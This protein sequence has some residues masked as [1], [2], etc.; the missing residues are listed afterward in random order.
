M[1]FSLRS[2]FG[3]IILIITITGIGLTE[4]SSS[5]EIRVPASEM[6]VFPDSSIGDSTKKEY[7]PSR[8]P[9]FG[10]S[11]YHG[12][13]M[14][15]RLTGSSLYLGLPSNISTEV[16]IDD[17]LKNYTISEKIGDDYYRP[18]TTLPYD[19]FYAMRKAEMDREYFK[20]KTLINNPKGIVDNYLRYIAVRIFGGLIYKR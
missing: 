17:S 4:P 19:R 8:R 18:P 10:S 9:N 1:R 3:V 7:V 2:I 11:D 6:L 12:N 13:S 16:E 14:T 15:D 5:V 20:E